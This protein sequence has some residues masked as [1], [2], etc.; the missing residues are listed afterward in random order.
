MEMKENIWDIL[1]DVPAWC[2]APGP[3]PEIRV[4]EPNAYYGTLLLEAYAGKA[5][6]MTAHLQ[7]IYHDNATRSPYLG[8]IWRCISRVE[9]FHMHYFG[10]TIQELGVDPRYYTRQNST[11]TLWTPDYIYWGSNICDRLKADIAAEQTAA[12]LQ[13][14]LSSQIDDPYVKAILAR[15]IRDEYWHKA[16]FTMAYNHYGCQ[17]PMPMP[18]EVPTPPTIPPLPGPPPWV[19]GMGPGMGHGMGP[20]MGPGPGMMPGAGPP[21]TRARG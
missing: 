11:T 8:E 19:P 13:M 16:I 18:P 4:K 14:K 1:R 17:P 6:E 12:D 10:M 20:G 5:G 9:Q 3:Y 15:V 2:R 21:W 7:Y